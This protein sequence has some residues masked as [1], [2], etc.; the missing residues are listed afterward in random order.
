MAEAKRLW[1]WNAIVAEE[2]GAE[3]LVLPGYFFHVFA[4]PFFYET[5][6]Y[7]AEFD[8]KVADLI[9][10]VREVYSGKL[11][12][13]GG[14]REFDFPSLADLVGVTTYD[15][16]HP[17]LPHDSTMDE[18]HSAYDVLFADKVDPIYQRW[19]KPVFLYTIH[20]P[21]LRD[22]PDPMG[23]SSQARQL[24][25]L[26]QALESRPWVAGTLSWSY[27]MIDAPLNPDD[28]VRARLAEAVL[29][30]YYGIFTGQ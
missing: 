15:T 20:F 21:L 4:P 3:V 29:A 13:S 23:Q 1:L 25:G 19:G 17:D 8:E 11:I 22:D 24:E 27:F 16:G 5:E 14:V 26:F 12:V 30:K 18:W 7:A 2:I 28:G 10:K 9:S 6:E